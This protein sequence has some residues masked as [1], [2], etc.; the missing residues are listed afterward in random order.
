MPSREPKTSKR[1]IAAAQ[2]AALAIEYRIAGMTL[3]EAARAAGYR[4]RSSAHGAITR[5]LAAHAAAGADELRA[6]WLARLDS[7]LQAIWPQVQRGNLGAIHALVR[8]S[9][10]ASAITGMDAPHKSTVGVEGEIEHYGAVAIAEHQR[11]VIDLVLTATADNPSAR[12][13]IAQRLQD[14]ADGRAA[15]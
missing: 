10:R 5:T 13:E 15:D 11:E 2:R 9:E 4:N 7:A 8:L 6:V 3:D 14:I 12:F 1:R